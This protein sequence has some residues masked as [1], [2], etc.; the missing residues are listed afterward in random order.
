MQSKKKIIHVENWLFLETVFMKNLRLLPFQ[1]HF[2][3][4]FN[5]DSSMY[6]PPLITTIWEI[7][8]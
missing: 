7:I 4:I 2:I 1:I 6:L 8:F 3:D 5:F